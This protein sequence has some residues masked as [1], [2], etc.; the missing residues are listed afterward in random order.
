M[1]PVLCSH[2]HQRIIKNAKGPSIVFSKDLASRRVPRKFSTVRPLAPDSRPTAPL[3]P[4]THLSALPVLTVCLPGL[5]LAPAPSESSHLH[6]FY[7]FFLARRRPFTNNRES[8]MR[9]AWSCAPFFFPV[10]SWSHNSHH[11]LASCFPRGR[12]LLV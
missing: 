12:T 2:R 1:V 10:E 9:L 3:P 6:L 8:S 5:R 4:L 11:N 7:F